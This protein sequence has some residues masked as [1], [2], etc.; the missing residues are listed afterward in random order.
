MRNGWL[1]GRLFGR[2]HA[3]WP[4]KLEMTI[5]AFQSR[6]N[7][8][9]QPRAFD[10]DEEVYSSRPRGAYR[11]YSVTGSGVA[12]VP[13]SGVLVHRAGQ[14]DATTSDPLRSYESIQA[15]LAMAANDRDVRAAVLRLDTP[16]GECTGVSATARAIAMLAEVMPV[17]ACADGY[18]LSAGMWLASAADMIVVEELGAVG[19]IGVVAAH[20]DMSGADRQD[21]F[22][23]RYYFQGDHKVD[24]NPHE[25]PT[26]DA[27]ALLMA[28][29]RSAYD[30][31][32][33]FVA[34]QRGMPVEEI[35]AT[36]AR[37]YSG[38]DAVTAGLADE[39]GTLSDAIALAAALADE[40]ESEGPR[41]PARPTQTRGF[42]MNT[43]MKSVATGATEGQTPVSPPPATPPA[44]PPA[45]APEPAKEPETPPQ[46]PAVPPAPPADTPPAAVPP[47]PSPAG[48]AAM[49]ERAEA[50][51]IVELCGLA[52]QPSRA[53][54][55]ISQG[56]TRGAVSEA[57]LRGRAE[58]GTRQDATHGGHQVNATGEHLGRPSAAA[59][60]AGYDPKAVAKASLAR[61]GHK[62]N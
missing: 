23:Y 25:A 1:M 38:A 50:A 57:L 32:T 11:P 22:A 12:V 18:A 2:P 35:V 28:D 61:L 51:A 56:L 33:G 60:P 37:V 39:V 45:P 20:V 14:I 46:P 47:A 7:L 30:M 40:A 62:T 41:T 6:L 8:R 13:I 16:G 4:A 54:E 15:D 58:G 26:P 55:F 48:A 21:G 42:R 59:L 53:A 43:R 31:F 9:A 17:V 52:G 27:E 10:D 29:I 5:A 36:Q 19:S 24:L 49:I 34:E 3:V 44:P